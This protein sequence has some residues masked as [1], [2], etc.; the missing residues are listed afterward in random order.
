[1]HILFTVSVFE[2]EIY[3]GGD[4]SKKPMRHC[5]LYPPRANI[6][7]FLFPPSLLLAVSYLYPRLSIWL[8][9]NSS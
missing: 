3:K 7:S 9:D 1:M 8:A 4:M 6:R 5:Y 2:K